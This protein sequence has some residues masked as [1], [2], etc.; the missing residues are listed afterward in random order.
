VATAARKERSPRRVA[1]VEELCKDD[2]CPKG[3]THWHPLT[4]ASLALEEPGEYDL[5]VRVR[6]VH[7]VKRN[8][9]RRRAR[10]A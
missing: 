1:V 7:V 10:A 2:S 8:R 6:V 9:G 3:P 5:T 4:I